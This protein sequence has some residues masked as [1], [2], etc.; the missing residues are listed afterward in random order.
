M[1]DLRVLGTMWPVL[2][3]LMPH[4]HKPPHVPVYSLLRQFPPISPG[5]EDP[6]KVCLSAHKPS[7]VMEEF[8]VFRYY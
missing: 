7:G 8:H 3:S 2:A 6:G 5:S 1:E 4:R